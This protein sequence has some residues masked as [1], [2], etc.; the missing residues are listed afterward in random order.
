MLA[1]ALA[2]PPANGLR[3]WT[4]HYLFGLIAVII[5]DIS[6]CLAGSARKSR[7]TSIATGENIRRRPWSARTSNTLPEP[8]IGIALGFIASGT[9]RTRST[10]RSPFASLAPFTTRGRRAESYARTS[11]RRCPCR[12][13]RRSSPRHCLLLAADRQRVFLRFDRKISVGKASNCDRDAKSVL[14][15]PL[16]IVRRIAGTPSLPRRQVGRAWRTSCRSRQLNDKGEQ[17]R[18]YAWHDLFV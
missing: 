5:R 17:N 13:R 7:G 3:R 12:A 4:Y 15:I 1:A 10:C 6:L 14:A 8:A 16:N 9:S 11:A 18:M 2:L